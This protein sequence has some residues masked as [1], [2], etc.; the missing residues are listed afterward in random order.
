MT[1]EELTQMDEKNLIATLRN[2]SVSDAI[3]R[4]CAVLLYQRNSR[5]CVHEEFQ[6]WK[7]QVL[8][9]VLKNFKENP[10]VFSSNTPFAALGRIYEVHQAHASQLPFGRPTDNESVALTAGTAQRKFKE[11]ASRS[12]C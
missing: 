4:S 6:P 11:S 3:R 7:P 8:D 5:F 9:H 2:P 1:A 10:P 12:W